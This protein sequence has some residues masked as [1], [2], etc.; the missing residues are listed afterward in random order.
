MSYSHRGA[1]KLHHTAPRCLRTCSDSSRFLLER[2]TISL[3]G[4]Y[5]LMYWFTLSNYPPSVHD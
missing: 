1:S 4:S 5:L 2:A 3:C